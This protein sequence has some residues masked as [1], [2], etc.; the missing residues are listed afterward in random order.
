MKYG[1]YFIGSTFYAIIIIFDDVTAVYLFSLWLRC[2]LCALLHLR[3]RRRR[4]SALPIFLTLFYCYVSSV[5][6]C[7][8]ITTTVYGMVSGSIAYLLVLIMAKVRSHYA[9]MTG[10]KICWAPLPIKKNYVTHTYARHNRRHIPSIRC[11][12]PCRYPI[13]FNPIQYNA[14]LTNLNVHE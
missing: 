11:W 2:R 3:L 1:A 5:I 12:S 4:L 9:K 8:L 13:Q 7:L 6:F 10:Y 14:R